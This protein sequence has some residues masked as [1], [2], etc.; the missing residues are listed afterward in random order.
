MYIAWASFRN[1]FDN[2]EWASFRNVYDSQEYCHELSIMVV[3]EFTLISIPSLNEY[4]HI[5]V[6]AFNQFIEFLAPHCH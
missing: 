1:V 2:Q 5:K 6:L 4:V 3:Y